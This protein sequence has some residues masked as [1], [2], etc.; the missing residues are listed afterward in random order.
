[1]TYLFTANTFFVLFYDL[2][3]HSKAIIF[4]VGPNS[5]LFAFRRNDMIFGLGKDLQYKEPKSDDRLETN[6]TSFA[7]NSLIQ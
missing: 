2:V 7:S 4:F 5:I 3:V 1:M 6:K